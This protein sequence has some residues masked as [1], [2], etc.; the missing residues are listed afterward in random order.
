MKINAY[1]FIWIEL[2][3][4]YLSFFFARFSKKNIIFV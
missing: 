4:Q 1:I 3:V 2:F